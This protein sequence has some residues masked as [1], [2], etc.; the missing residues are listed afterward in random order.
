MR[1]I[2]P[3]HCSLKMNWGNCSPML[4][5]C[6][7][8]RQAHEMSCMRHWADSATGTVGTHTHTHTYLGMYAYFD[9]PTNNSCV[10]L[11]PL[12]FLIIKD[13]QAWIQDFIHMYWWLNKLPI[14]EKVH[15]LLSKRAISALAWLY[16]RIYHPSFIPSEYESTLT[17]P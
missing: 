7:S 8:Q 11:V 4:M 1:P 12:S 17:H 6:F 2:L 16:P 3:C 10:V 15:Y 5:L 9:Y 13:K 14:S